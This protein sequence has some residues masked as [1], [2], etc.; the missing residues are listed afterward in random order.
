MIGK[1][2]RILHALGSMNPGGI[3]KWLLNVLGRIDHNSFQFDFCTFG[4]EPGIFAPEVEGLG[5]KILLCPKGPNPWS[6]RRRFQR[7]L[8]DNRYDVVHSHVA[9]FSGAILR[10]AKAEGVPVRIA[11]S[12]LSQDDRPSTLARRYYRRLMKS[13]IHRYATRGLAASRLAAVE[14]FG[15]NWDK[16]VRYR[17]L[18]YGIDLGPFVMPVAREQV[19]Q[20]LGIPADAIVVGHVGRFVEA[21]NHDFLLKIAGEILR[22]HPDV[23]FLFVGDGPLRPE[24]EARVNVMSLGRNIHFAGTRTDVPRLMRGAMDVFAFPSLFEG[25]GLVLLEAQA[26]GLPCVVSDTIS[27]ETVMSK[28]SIEFLALSLSPDHWASRIV[29]MFGAGRREPISKV[30]WDSRSH[31]SIRRS[32]RE[33]ADIYESKAECADIRSAANLGSGTSSD[34]D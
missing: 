33:L 25:F 13:W 19:R 29:R 11:H 30:D 18:H 4:P 3:E 10:W 8:R 23:H 28:S 26:A 32:V 31:F 34:R 20:E 6:F 22:N 1:Q 9:L 12:H 17:V 7:I 16:D 5:G 21:K 27:P 14:L 15:E 2:I 24:I